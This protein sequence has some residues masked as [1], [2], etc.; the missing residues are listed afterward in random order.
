[1]YF[2]SVWY[3]HKIIVNISIKIFLIK[4]LNAIKLSFS[5]INIALYD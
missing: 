3:V 4:I 5:Y 2:E 1:M